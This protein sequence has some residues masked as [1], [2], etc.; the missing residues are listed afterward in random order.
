M[1]PFRTKPAGRSDAVAIIDDAIEFAAE[2][3]QYFSRSVAVIP[4]SG[5]RE[6]IGLFARSLEPSLHARLPALVMAPQQVI[7]LI[8][9]KG[10]EQSGAV[11][12][13]EIERA[14]GIVLPP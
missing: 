14:L 5:L 10:V 11:S 13:G 1:W 6:R 2:R 9:A 12:R 3:W 7:L 4:G 8:I